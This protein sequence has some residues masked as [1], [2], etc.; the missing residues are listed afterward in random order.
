[1]AECGGPAKGLKEGGEKPGKREEGMGC[2]Q[3]CT[4]MGPL[5]TREKRKRATDVKPNIMLGG[6]SGSQRGEGHKGNEKEEMPY[7]SKEGGGNDHTSTC[8]GKKAYLSPNRGTGDSQ[9][10][11]ICPLRG[12]GIG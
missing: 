7:I 6:K 1:V 3:K 4:K 12:E 10:N 11:D 2:E 9:R 5:R 8:R